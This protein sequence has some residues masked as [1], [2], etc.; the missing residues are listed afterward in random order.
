MDFHSL[1]KICSSPLDLN[2]L[3]QTIQQG[4]GESGAAVIFTGAVRVSSEEQGLT[5]M[6]LEHYPG[7]TESQLASILQEASTRWSLSN[8]LV[9]HR[10]G[11]LE[12]G[13]PIVFVGVCSLH[14][15]EAF[16]ATEFIMDYLKQKATFWKKEHYGQETVWVD[17]KESDT[18]A[19]ERWK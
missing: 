2:A 12:A 6:T 8:M 13:E 11:Y 19:A 16:E 7:M 4:K 18:T 10:V 3:N 1:I 14:R 5:G 15:K 17:A 9:A